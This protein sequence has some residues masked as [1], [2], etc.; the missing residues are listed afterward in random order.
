[1][2]VEFKFI[3]VSMGQ[4]DCCL[5]RC[6]DGKVVVDCGSKANAYDPEPE[7]IE[8]AKWWLRG[9]KWA[10]G[11]KNTVSALI[12]THSD[13][14]HYNKVIDF[15]AASSISANTELPW[16]RK[17]L[18][19]KANLAKIEIDKIYIGNGYFQKKAVGYTSPMQHYKAAAFLGKPTLYDVATKKYR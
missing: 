19:T 13:A 16:S 12:L 9:N 2:A 5:A 11:H 18:T 7:G 4:G 14:D 15:F 1:M 17:T 6:P 10:G 3:F 8:E